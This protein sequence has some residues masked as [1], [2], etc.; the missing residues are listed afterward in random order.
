MHFCSSWK[1]RTEAS[2]FLLLPRSRKYWFSLISTLEN[3]FGSHRNDVKVH[4]HLVLCTDP[5][6]SQLLFHS[7]LLMIKKVVNRSWLFFPIL[8]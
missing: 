5:L 8:K 6:G 3:S 4:N 7:F 2:H 1:E